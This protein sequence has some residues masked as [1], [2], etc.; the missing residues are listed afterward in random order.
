MTCFLGV[1]AS[2]VN[3][4][5]SIHWLLLWKKNTEPIHLAVCAQG[6]DSFTLLRLDCIMCLIMKSSNN[7]NR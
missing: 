1:F 5:N 3:V 6:T 7:K 4:Q 2:L